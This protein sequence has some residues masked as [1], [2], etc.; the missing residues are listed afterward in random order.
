MPWVIALLSFIAGY[1]LILAALVW[2]ACQAK[3][4]GDRLIL[5][6]IFKDAEASVE[7]VMWDLF[8]LKSWN[9]QGLNFLVIDDKSQDDTLPIL[10]KMRKRYP[11]ILISTSYR[12]K[13]E[14]VI[15]GQGRRMRVLKVTGSECPRLVRKK[16][17][18]LLNQLDHCPAEGDPP[19]RK[20][21]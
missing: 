18:F 10:K 7:A 16:I 15:E 14:Q 5:I 20:Y 4:E 19:L 6:L 8:R 17:L 3:I 2:S 11:F 21:S 9:Y 13:V 1:F 12:K